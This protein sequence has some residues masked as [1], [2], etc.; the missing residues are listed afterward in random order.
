[1]LRAMA[2]KPP[3]FS[4]RQREVLRLIGEGQKTEEIAASLGVTPATAKVYVIKVVERVRQRGRSEVGAAPWPLTHREQEV[5]QLVAAGLSDADIAQQLGISTRTAET[6]VASVRRKLGL[7]SRQ[8]LT[9]PRLSRRQSEIR[10]L[11]AK[12]LTSPQIA[13]RLGLSRRTVDSHVGALMQRAGVRRRGE[14][15]D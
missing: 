14:L 1:M 10:A 12:G 9:G 13:E 11:V 2:R 3:Q 5:Q 15:R 8:Q 7:T 6:H 4:D